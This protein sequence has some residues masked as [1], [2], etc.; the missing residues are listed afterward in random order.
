[1]SDFLPEIYEEMGNQ[2]IEMLTPCEPSLEE[3]EIFTKGIH[4]LQYK[5]AQYEQIET[6]LFH[7]FANGTYVRELHM[8]ANAIFI[9]KT[10]RFEHI[11]IVSKGKAIVA[12][13]N[14]VR[15][16]EAPLT[17]VSKAGAKRAF[18]VIED[19]IFSTV[20]PVKTNDL[21]QIEQ[22]VIVKDE[23]VPEFRKNLYLEN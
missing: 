12:D 18:H 7:H 4:E 3:K 6:K 17:F 22:D 23:D 16:V 9:G 21:E 10:H 20:H 8:P 5:L 11:V 19:L 1:M 15:Y 13:E 2:L 14:G